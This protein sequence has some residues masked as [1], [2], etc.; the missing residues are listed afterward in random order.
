MIWFKLM[1]DEV[2]G[3]P[4]DMHDNLRCYTCAVAVE[5]EEC[6]SHG[7]VRLW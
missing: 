1:V 5:Y 2:L 6:A 4:N 7:G 3:L